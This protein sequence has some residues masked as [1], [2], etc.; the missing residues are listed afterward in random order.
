MSLKGDPINCRFGSG[1]EA[2]PP[3]PEET[4][5]ETAKDK[6]SNLPFWIK[7]DIDGQGKKWRLA[8]WTDAVGEG[9]AAFDICFPIEDF[10]D[11]GEPYL[12]RPIRYI[13]DPNDHPAGPSTSLCG[14]VYV[15]PGECAFLDAG[16]A[17]IEKLEKK[18]AA[19][20]GLPSSIQ[21]ALNSGDGSY[22]P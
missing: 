4:A 11:A 15:K 22:R 19:S 6:P 1:G 8:F 21:E 9:E 3:D 2:D 7:C 10:Q 16:I 5:E 17:E 18:L 12:D 14:R 20:G 13:A